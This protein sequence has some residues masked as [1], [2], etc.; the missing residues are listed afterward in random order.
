MYYSI[1]ELF[2]GYAKAG[3]GPSFQINSGSPSAQPSVI[4]EGD[5]YM[6]IG[7]SFYMRP[8]RKASIELT[9]TSTDSTVTE[10]SV[11]WLFNN[12]EI[13][14]SGGRVDTITEN[15][16]T[17]LKQYSVS[18]PDIYRMS[19]ISV[20]QTEVLVVSN[21]SKVISEGIYTAEVSI[22]RLMEFYYFTAVDLRIF[23]SY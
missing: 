18:H 2:L 15:G 12:V 1:I 19:D 20:S 16:K 9:Y 7:S 6:N 3:G 22:F 17:F 21:V 5:Q 23:R 10:E 11:R 14:F 8:G 4:P 13:N